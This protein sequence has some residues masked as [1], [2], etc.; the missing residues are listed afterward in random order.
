MPD[1]VARKPEGIGAMQ[2][3]GL[4]ALRLSEPCLQLRTGLRR[5]GREHGLGVIHVQIR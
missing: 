3:A 1:Y 5:E 2:A 4:P